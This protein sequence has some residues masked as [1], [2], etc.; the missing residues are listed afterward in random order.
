[1]ASIRYNKK[2]SYNTGNSEYA[3]FVKTIKQKIEE[4]NGK[5]GD[6]KDQFELMYSLERKFQYHVSKSAQCEK[7][8][9]K[10]IIHVKKEL[11][12]ILK[13]KGFFREKKD[14][15]SRHISGAIK[16][17]NA[18]ELSKYQ[19]NYNLVLFLINNW[20]L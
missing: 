3:K 6:Q 1:M 8:Y 18:K 20:K 11:G 9:M 17:Y 16:E 2:V 14:V 13:A 12:N 7:V 19:M 5:I 10:I 15:L 4:N